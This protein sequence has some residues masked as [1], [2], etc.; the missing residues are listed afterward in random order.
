MNTAKE[1]RSDI[2]EML[3]QVEDIEILQAIRK[4]L[5]GIY[6]KGD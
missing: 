4:E 2:S 5:E 1:I 3:I 6:N